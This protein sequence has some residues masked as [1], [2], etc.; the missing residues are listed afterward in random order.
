[1]MIIN[2]DHSDWSDWWYLTAVLIF[3][4]PV[5]SDVE[6]FF[7]CLLAICMSSLEECLFRSSA[8]F[9]IGLL[10]CLLF[11]FLLLNEFITFVCFLV[12]ELFEL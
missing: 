11:F 12:V 8:H 6:H 1:M 5:I 4:S 2:D 10:G 9:L 7:M 3:I